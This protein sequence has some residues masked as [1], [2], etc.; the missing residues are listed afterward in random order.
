MD[1][2]LVRAQPSA[3]GARK[4]PR[5]KSGTTDMG[6]VCNVPDLG[7]SVSDVSKVNE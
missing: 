6:S 5:D 1:T 2:G 3:T 4:G 7:I